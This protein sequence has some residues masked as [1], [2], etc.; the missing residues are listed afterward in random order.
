MNQ[1]SDL[2]GKP[3]SQYRFICGTD[4]TPL[5]LWVGTTT[6]SFAMSYQTFECPTCKKHYKITAEWDAEIQD[7]KILNVEMKV[8]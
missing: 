1:Y 7:Y 5:R 8:R 3:L 4:G 6:N 2:I